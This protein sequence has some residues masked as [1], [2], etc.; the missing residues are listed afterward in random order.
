M[1]LNDDVVWHALLQ[2]REIARRNAIPDIGIGVRTGDAALVDARDPTACAVLLPSGRWRAVDELNDSAAGLFHLYLPLA[3]AAANR[4]HVVGQIGQSVDGHIATVTGASCYVTGP[5]SLDHLHRL[6][7]LADAVI[8]GAGTVAADD[9]QLTTRRVPGPNPVRVV[10]DPRLRSRADRRL[11][12]D[13]AASTMV[14]SADTTDGTAPGDAQLAR[15]SAPDGQVAAATILEFLADRGLHAVLVEGGGVT[16]SGFLHQGG[17]H[18]LHVVVAPLI[19]GS[20]RPGLRLPPV[21]DLASAMRPQCRHHRL[22]D[23]ILFE[24]RFDDDGSS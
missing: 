15:L 10:I 24:F 23:D 8:V 20:G 11:F 16:V 1:S 4:P 6:R 9:P 21:D 18:S 19:I 14:L 17:L 22:G 3:V 7:A 2:V 12:G 5:Q 13:G